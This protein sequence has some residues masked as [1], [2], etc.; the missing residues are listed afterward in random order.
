LYMKAIAGFVFAAL[1][2]VG[3]AHQNT[4]IKPP[5]VAV[6]FPQSIALFGATLSVATAPAPKP[7][8]P[9]A[10][11]FRPVTTGI[12]LGTSTIDG[13]VTQSQLQVAIEQASNALRQLIYANAGTVG[14]GQYSTGGY[15]N[16]LALSTKID[17]L[18]GTTLTNVVVN[19]VSGL[20]AANIPDLSSQYLPLSGGTIT[21]GL[22]VTGAFSGGNISLNAASSTNSLSLNATSTNLFASNLTLGSALSIA[23]GGTGTTTATG[24]ISHLQFLFP[25]ASNASARSVQS[26]LADTVSVKDFGRLVQSYDRLQK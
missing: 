15:T 1:S 2:I 12:V 9:V 8:K 26:K 6:T 14:Q 19:G 23:N 13:V 5:Q 11:A 21:G 18:S 7:S 24:V 22:T 16:N 20:T 17:Q 4:S 10:I 3:L 25:S